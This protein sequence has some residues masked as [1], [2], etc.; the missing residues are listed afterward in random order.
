[1]NDMWYFGIFDSKICP[2]NTV[3]GTK[4]Y[5]SWGALSIRLLYLLLWSQFKLS[6]TI[7]PK[8]NG[9]WKGIFM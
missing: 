5:S 1:V 3:W 8:V 2:L 9:Q 6:H 7:V 4:W